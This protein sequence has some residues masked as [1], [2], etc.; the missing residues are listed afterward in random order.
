MKIMGFDSVDKLINRLNKFDSESGKMCK[1][2]LFDGAAVVADRI[3]SGI[4]SIPIQETDKGK[5]P[6]GTSGHPLTGITSVQKSG[7]MDGFGVSRFRDEGGSI[8]TSIGFD[9]YNSDGKPNVVIARAV[10][11]G[12][13][14]R[15]KHPF[16]R[17]AMNAVK[18]NA[19]EA[20]KKKILEK[21]K[22]I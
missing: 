18:G 13:S 4:D 21:V 15:R 6:W 9:G 10:E 2:A 8:T 19:E 20:M 11:S 3:K 22:E 17:P 1:E 5:A 7:L 16:V 12:S 14:F